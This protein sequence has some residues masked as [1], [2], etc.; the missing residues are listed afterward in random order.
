[1]LKSVDAE[2]RT[3]LYLLLITPSFTIW[4]SV[5]G[6]EAILVG[7]TG[8]IAAYLVDLFNHRARITLL[9]LASVIVLAV[10]KP[11]YLPAIIFIYFVGKFIRYFRQRE[12]LTLCAGLIS[13]LILYLASDY[14][15]KIS[16]QIAPH[17]YPENDN[18][19]REIF[20]VEPYD[21]FWKAPY[22]MFQ[23]LYGPTL[24]EAFGGNP[25]QFL[26]FFES[27]VMLIILLYFG[28]RR[29]PKLPAL[30]AISV[31]FAMFWILFLNYPFGIM[32]PGSAIRYRT[33][34]W[35]LIV[36]FMIALV[37]RD[38]HRR[39]STGQPRAAFKPFLIRKR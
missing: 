6:K 24:A 12:L 17:F 26:T 23:S 29:L 10:I 31:W 30:N 11:H 37:S 19:T 32:N 14:I 20:W 33:G 35:L 27:A 18:S 39:W 4:S 34:Y 8:I 9:L 16:F 13:V 15:D 21:I 1:L 3:Y 5:A 22:G 38:L 2:T 7:V 25:L 28:Y 36:F